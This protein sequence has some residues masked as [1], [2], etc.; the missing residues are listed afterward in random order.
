MAT[1]IPLALLGALLFAASAAL[2]HGTV[3]RAAL[4]GARLLGLLRG[5]F[6]QPLWLLGWVVNVAGFTVQA[7]ALHLGS[8]AVVQALMVT[9]LVFALPLS[10]HK[11][12]RRDW[13]AAVAICAGLATV[14]WLRGTVPQEVPETGRA[15]GVVAGAVVLILLLR[16]AG[17]LLRRIP[18]AS[19]GAC[20]S[21]AGISFCVS[22]IFLTLTGDNVARH[23]VVGG[24]IGW[25]TVGLCVS[26]LVG[27]VQV[28]DAFSRG[29]LPTAMIAMTVVD[30]VASWIAGGLLFDARPAVHTG[31]LVGCAIAAA[32]IVAGVVVV[33]RSPTLHGEPPALPGLGPR[34]RPSR[35]DGGV[36]VQER[37]D[38]LGPGV[39]LGGRPGGGPP[40][41][42]GHAKQLDDGVGHA[43]RGA[44]ADHT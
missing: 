44:V 19:A 24:L 5:L 16:L 11:P 31:E 42:N 40:L 23:G 29:S 26:T 25:P 1:S 14:L 8:I 36:P 15:L 2:Q 18:Q 32:V 20:A 4:R 3:R 37:G 17:W 6:R 30:P 35:V 43:G 33:A 27:L 10:G 38:R 13:A 21:A 28:Q 34:S 41:P 7:V 39:P 12:L 9:Q 22:A